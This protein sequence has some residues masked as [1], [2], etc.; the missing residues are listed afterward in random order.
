VILRGRLRLLFAIAFVQRFC[1]SAMIVE[2]VV[3]PNGGFE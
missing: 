2:I 1:C 3:L